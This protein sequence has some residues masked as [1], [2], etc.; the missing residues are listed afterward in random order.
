VPLNYE[1]AQQT[2][3]Q[4]QNDHIAKIIKKS[5][6]GKT[7]STTIS[8][9]ETMIWGGDY[10]PDYTNCAIFAKQIKKE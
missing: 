6:F 3:C 8:D 4:E 7:I 1:K 10:F 9:H 2:P 5:Q